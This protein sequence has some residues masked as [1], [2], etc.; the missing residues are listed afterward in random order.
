MGSKRPHQAGSC[1]AF[2]ETQRWC[3]VRRLRDCSAP[4]RQRAP[5]RRRRRLSPSRPTSPILPLL[6]RAGHF[7]AVFRAHHLTEECP[8]RPPASGRS[9]PEAEAQASLA[10]MS[11]GDMYDGSAQEVRRG[12]QIGQCQPTCRALLVNPAA[13]SAETPPTSTRSVSHPYHRIDAGGD[14]IEVSVAPSAPVGARGP[15]QKPVPVR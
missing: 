15:P 4:G 9:D 3:K 6:P 8:R 7:A 5:P 14:G 10:R 12:P 2:R 1:A 13:I 11:F